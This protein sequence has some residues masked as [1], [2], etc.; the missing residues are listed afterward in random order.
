[1]YRGKYRLRSSMKIFIL[2]IVVALLLFPL[3]GVL[4][5]LVDVDDSVLCEGVVSPEFSFDL[6]SH[7]DGRLVALNVRTG[8]KVKKGDVLAEIDSTP[9]ED[10]LLNLQME[11]YQLEA[12]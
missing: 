11:I 8:Q 9:Y 7:I 3:A 6:V 2:L 4:L 5:F 12:E 10:D 1:M